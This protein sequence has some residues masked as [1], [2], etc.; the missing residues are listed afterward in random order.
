MSLSRNHLLEVFNL[1][2]SFFSE[3]GEIRAVEDIRFSIQ[4]GQTVAFVGESGCGKT[5]VAK[6]LLRIEQPTSGEV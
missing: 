6:L 4:P 3:I 1:S 2:T 5:T